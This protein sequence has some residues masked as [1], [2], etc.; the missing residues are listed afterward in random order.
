[1]WVDNDVPTLK[2]FYRSPF[3]KWLP[4]WSKI[5]H[6]RSFIPTWAIL[7]DVSVGIVF[8]ISIKSTMSH[9]FHK[10]YEYRSCS[11]LFISNHAVIR[12]VQHHEQF[13]HFDKKWC[14]STLS[15]IIKIWYVGR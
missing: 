13:V 7:A 10:F 14:S 6:K 1:M 4:Q 11:C 2:N 12:K 15:N 3:S 9:I 8:L 5:V